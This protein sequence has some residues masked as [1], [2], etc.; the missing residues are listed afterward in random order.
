MTKNTIHS[1]YDLK[2]FDY[3]L[4]EAPFNKTVYVYL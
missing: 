1:L 4:Q 2:F 3:T